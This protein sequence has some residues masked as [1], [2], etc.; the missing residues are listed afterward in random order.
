MR[1]RRRRDLT[2]SRQRLLIVYTGQD[3]GKTT[4]ASAWCYA[5][6]AGPT[7]YP[8]H[9]GERGRWGETVMAERLGIAWHALGRGFSLIRRPAPR[10]RWLRR[11]G[12]GLSR[13]PGAY[14]LVA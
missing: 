6:W 13:S 3:K 2:A 8:V 12:P 9:Q 10:P 11:L 1:A 7:P 14:D 4:A 5:P